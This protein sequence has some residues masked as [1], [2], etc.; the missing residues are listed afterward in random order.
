MES[1]PL[2]T[3]VV[4]LLGGLAFF[5]YG[6]EKL[7]SALKQ[8]AGDRM[9]RLLAM[10]TTNRFK[11]V[12]AGAFITATIQSSS[13][14]TVLVVG[15]ISAG[16]LSLSQSI[17]IIMGAEIGTTITAQIIAFNITRWSVLLVAIGFGLL[18][19][20]KREL[21]R[22]YGSMVMGLGL[23]FYG[24]QMMKESTSPLRSY[25][26]FID[27]M[28]N[29]SNPL[30]AVVFGALFTALVQSSSATTGI[31]IVLASQGLLTL[32]AGIPLVF[33]ANIGTCITA[34]LASIGKPRE[35]VRAA[36]VHV[37]F[38]TSGVLIWIGLIPYL[39]DFVRWLSPVATELEG[40]AKLQRETPRQI[41]NAHTTF[42][43]ANTLLFIGFTPLMARFVEWLIPDRELEETEVAARSHLDELLLKTPSLALDLARMEVGRLGAATLKM[44]DAAPEPVL[45][46][47]ER[48]LERLRAM[49]AE[50]DALHAGLIGY[51]GRL[52]MESLSEAQSRR[53]SEYVAC[54]NHFENIGDLIETNLVDEGRRRLQENLHLSEV[55]R[56]EL[57]E[58]HSKI[59]WSVER[60]TQ[61]MVAEDEA[62][63]REVIDAKGEVGRLAAEVNA[64]LARRLTAEEPNRL[65]VYR[66]EAELVEGL[67]RIYYHAKRI[68]KR[69]AQE[70]EAAAPGDLPRFDSASDSSAEVS[71]AA[72]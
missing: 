34:F 45:V 6:M 43:V 41:A 15:F 51:L 33:G 61:A 42:N 55:T 66:V 39:A 56:G 14:T 54:A 27:S 65:A 22:Q 71:V 72:Q 64:H 37:L 38:N 3:I 58:L 62:A 44:V 21:A 2:G 53:L 11:G 31:I 28:Q 36:A 5:L 20:A 68:A 52:S 26:P 19:F 16:L 4:G 29:L 18:F 69:I 9:K 1:L 50:V 59:R 23:I 70:G 13:V 32:E 30:L 57:E 10:M 63:A 46:G 60:V 12:A 49:D 7:T 67:K 47:S 8:V 25:E 48:D 35:A 40:L 17:P 24:M